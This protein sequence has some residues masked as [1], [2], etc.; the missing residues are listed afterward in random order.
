MKRSQ[1]LKSLFASA[2]ALSI[3]G[4]LHAQKEELPQVGFEHLP[5]RKELNMNTIIHRAETRGHANH[6]WLASHHTFSFASYMNPERVHFGALRVLN[7]DIIKGGTGFGTHPHENMEIVSIPLYGALEHKDSTGR[8]KVI[9]TGDVQIMSAGS[10]I[11]HSEYNHLKDGDT[12]FLQIWV[13]PKTANIAP[14]YEQQ[15]FD[16]KNRINQWQTV[17]SPKEGDGLWINQDA[18][19]NL[20]NLEEGKSITYTKQ[21]ADSVLYLFIISGKVEF[22]GETLNSRD[23][24]GISEGELEN[25][26][27]LEY[28]ELLLMEL[29]HLN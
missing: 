1:F 26:K 19:F 27:A 10:G 22:N 3:P 23:G 13:F 18:W 5:L 28:S 14:R 24:I 20:S 25:L 17:V 12:N 7:D 8:H 11:Y 15:A 9:Q 2:S 21:K 29:P 6:G 4:A 16:A